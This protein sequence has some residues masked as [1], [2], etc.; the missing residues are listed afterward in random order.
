M[1]IDTPQ[2]T[3]FY[4][5]I[6]LQLVDSTKEVEVSKLKPG[7]ILSGQT[8]GVILA[9]FFDVVY[10]DAYNAFINHPEVNRNWYG[11]ISGPGE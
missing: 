7:Q 9:D 1:K 8:P 4:Y 6:T 2:K 3:Q 10:S 11:I 5:F